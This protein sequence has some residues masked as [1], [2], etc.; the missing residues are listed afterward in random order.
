LADACAEALDLEG[1]ADLL[2]DAGAALR[3]SG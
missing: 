2:G 3:R 1:L